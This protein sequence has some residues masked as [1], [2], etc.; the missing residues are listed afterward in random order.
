MAA[1]IRATPALF[2]FPLELYNGN[3]FVALG[4][5]PPPG[6]LLS[7]LSGPN[8]QFSWPEPPLS[9]GSVQVDMAGDLLC[10]A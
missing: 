6:T 5:K 4:F 2:L 9:P 1:V 7:I 8:K 10:S 3:V